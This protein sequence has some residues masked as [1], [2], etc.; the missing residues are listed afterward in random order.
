MP[1]RLLVAHTPAERDAARTV[2][3]RVFLQAFGNTPEVMEQ[4][5]GPFEARSRFVVVLDE[6]SGTALG[7]ARLILPDPSAGPVKTLADVAGDPWRVDVADALGRAGLTGGPVWDVA[8][9]AVDR[10]FRSG[11]GGAELTLALCHGILEHPRICGAEGLV[12]VL[13]DKV[14]RLLRVMGVPWAPLPGAASRPYLGSPA[15]TPCVMR[16]DAVGESIRARRPDVA[17]AVVD[18]VFGSIHLDP[19]D[20]APGRGALLPE[21]DPL[22]PPGH[23]LVPTA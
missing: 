10:R 17:P 22:V 21:V 12:T 13:D 11:A 15:S 19:A 2:E 8:S 4:E 20:L 5:Y 3:G 16:V 18:G 14:L 1:V 23:P 9:L 7:A 6:D